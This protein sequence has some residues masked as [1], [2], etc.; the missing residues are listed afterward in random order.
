MKGYLLILIIGLILIYTNL[1]IFMLFNNVPSTKVA[2]EN[3]DLFIEW[4][5]HISEGEQKGFFINSTSEAK[6][7]LINSEG[8]K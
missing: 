4:I 5:N 1:F 3:D 2:L 6:P 8:T 7:I